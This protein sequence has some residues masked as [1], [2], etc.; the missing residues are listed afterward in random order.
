MDTKQ[1]IRE[2]FAKS[3]VAVH[4]KLDDRIIG[5]A[6]MAFGRFEGAGPGSASLSIWRTFMKNR[7]T[8]IAAA[9]MTIIA[10]LVAIDHFGGSVSVSGVVWADVL[11][12][13]DATRTVMY[14]LEIENGDDREVFTSRATEPYRWRLDTI[15]SPNRYS[16]SIH[17][18]EINKCLLL[19]PDTKMAVLNN[20]EGYP[21]YRINTYEKLKRDLR[22]GTEKNLGTVTLDGRDTVCFEIEKGSSVITVWADPQTALPIRIEEVSGKDGRMRTLRSEIT[23]D[24]EFDEQLFSMAPPEGYSL[25]DFETGRI[26]TPFELTEK[27]LIEGLAVYPKYL[28]GRFCTRFRGGKPMTDELRKKC[29]EEVQKLS[30]SDEEANKSS[31]ACEFIDRL[32]DGSDYQYVGEDV[33]F[34]DADVP[35][36]WWKPPGSKTYRVIYSDLSVRDVEAAD[37]PEVPWLEEKK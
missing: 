9:A 21:G 28:D 15:E 5:D 3:D 33:T 12:K 37:L 1:K 19:Y 34:G 35:V 30:W 36:C 8:E 25:L 2:L 18:G 20:D 26:Q 24:I 17:D 10:A 4:A 31:L 22:D 23:F 13:V 32:P 16:A 11:E 14:V 7:K 29:S 6:L 27:H